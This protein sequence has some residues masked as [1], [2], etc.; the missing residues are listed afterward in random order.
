MTIERNNLS[1]N[2]GKIEIFLKRRIY[3]LYDFDLQK[4]RGGINNNEKYINN[5]HF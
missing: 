3:I 4:L 1:K 2:T 5:R